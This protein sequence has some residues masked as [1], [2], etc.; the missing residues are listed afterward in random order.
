[1]FIYKSKRNNTKKANPNDYFRQLLKKLLNGITNQHAGKSIQKA[2]TY[3]AKINNSNTLTSI[4]I[5]RKWGN[6]HLVSTH[7]T[8]HYVSNINKIMQ[9]Y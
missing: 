5:E 3:L 4:R 1:M 6:K 2:T 9:N 7:G 8:P